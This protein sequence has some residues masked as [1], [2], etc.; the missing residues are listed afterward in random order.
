MKNITKKQR[1][2][3]AVITAVLVCALL[4]AAYLTKS[5]RDMPESEIPQSQSSEAISNNIGAGEI[6]YSSSTPPK[7]L[8]PDENS[9]GVLTIEKIGLTC[10]VYD[11][12]PETVMEDMRA[13]AAHYNTTSYWQGNIGLSAHNGNASYSYFNKLHLL[14]RG[15]AILYE[16]TMGIRH[17]KVVIVAEI[18]DTDWSYLDGTDDNRITLTTC[19]LGKP[20]MRLCVQAVEI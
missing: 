1:V 9:I 15:D 7:Q 8:V 16:T 12:T 2:V 3:F 6:D 11:S 10:H 18:A 20:E 17:Y 13:G 4:A 19:V 14:E 5:Q